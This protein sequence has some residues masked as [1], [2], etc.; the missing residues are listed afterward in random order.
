MADTLQLEHDGHPILYEW[1]PSFRHR[2]RAKQ[3]IGD[4]AESYRIV[5][6]PSAPGCIVVYARY[7]GEWR[8]NCGERYLIARLLEELIEAWKEDRISLDSL[9]GDEEGADE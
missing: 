8:A 5:S 3:P 4:I 6:V 7:K 9:G 1:T 2:A